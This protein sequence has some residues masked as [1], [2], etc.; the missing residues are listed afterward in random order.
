MTRN[1]ACVSP[2]TDI[3]TL[4]RLFM[5]RAISGAP[6]VDAEGYPIGVV[7]RADLIRAA[8]GN[9]DEKFELFALGKEELAL[10]LEAG[11]TA[12]HLVRATAED[13][14]MPVALTVP[15]NA[16][17]GQAAALIAL[18]GVHRLPV[19]SSDNQVVGIISSNDIVRFVAVDEGYLSAARGL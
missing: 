10:E 3:A 16:P 6:V 19:L 8:W 12:R 4:A 9:A 14:M 2:E 18:E 15:E 11:V 17:I 5:D 13:L 7:T 1:V